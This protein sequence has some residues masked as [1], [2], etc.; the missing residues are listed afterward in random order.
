MTDLYSPFKCMFMLLMQNYAELFGM[1]HPDSYDAR[2]HFLLNYWPL[3][4]CICGP[5]IGK[6]KGTVINS[7]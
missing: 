1:T 2:P 5:K 6:I 4:L 7:W 3:K